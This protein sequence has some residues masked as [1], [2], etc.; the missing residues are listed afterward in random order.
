MCFSDDNNEM[1]DTSVA[2]D[3][4]NVHHVIHFLGL[5]HRTMVH[6][7]FAKYGMRKSSSRLKGKES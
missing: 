6:N 5:F 2:T 3:G 7:N 1:R 4:L